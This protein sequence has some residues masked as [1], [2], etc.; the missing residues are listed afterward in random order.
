MN[1]LSIVYPM[2]ALFGL[3]FFI[4]YLMLVVRV[5][6]VRER[7]ISPRYFKLNKGGELPEKVEAI[8]QNYTN[9]LE[10]P[11]LFYS[12]CIIAIVLN[13]N[14]EYFIICAWAFVLSRIIHSYIHITYNHILHRLAAFAVSGFIL[15]FMWAKVL[16]IVSTK[17]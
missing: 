15:I 5:K 17:I 16:I 3:T 7:K 12:V 8:A 2:A 10:L 9:L 1:I 4:M 14:A 11:V 13:Q 6:A